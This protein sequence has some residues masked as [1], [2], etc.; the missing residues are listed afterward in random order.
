MDFQFADLKKPKPY[1]PYTYDPEPEEWHV[2]N[3]FPQ[4][5][6]LI[7]EVGCGKGAWVVAQAKENPE[8]FYIG[9]ERTI[10]KSKTLLNTSGE[11][12]LKNLIAIQAD[13]IALISQKFPKECVDELFFFYPNPTPK[14]RQAN[15]RFFV[16]SAFEVFDQCLKQNGTITLVTNIEPYYQEAS[17]FLEK[18]WGYQI[19]DKKK[20]PSDL[21]PRTAFEKRYLESSD[22]LYELTASK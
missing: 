5:K 8:T 6:K 4:V 7:V 3:T 20:L 2:L 16:S 12:A 22:N 9:I 17:A 19:V 15:Q 1:S 11:A 13:A 18:I 10:N 14:K 21:K